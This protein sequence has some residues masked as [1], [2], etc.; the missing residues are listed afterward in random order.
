[1]T[2]DELIEFRRSG[3]ERGDCT[4]PYEVILK[5][6]C[7]VREFINAVLTDK[8]EWGEIY[9]GDMYN[10]SVRM[11]PD[12]KIEYRYGSICKGTMTWDFERFL[13]VEVIG[14]KADGGWTRM[15]YGLE[16]RGGCD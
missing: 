11:D 5:K 14:V 8:R 16:L 7:T 13:D 6:K 1:M 15:D 4:A 9:L 12:K 2:K 3:N 10:W